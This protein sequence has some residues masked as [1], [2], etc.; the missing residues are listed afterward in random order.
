MPITVVVVSVAQRTTTWLITS[1]QR[2]ISARRSSAYSPNE[3]LDHKNRAG[4]FLAC[5]PRLLWLYEQEQF[6]FDQIFFCRLYSNAL[7]IKRPLITMPC[8]EMV[9]WRARGSYYYIVQLMNSYRLVRPPPPSSQPVSQLAVH[10]STYPNECKWACRTIKLSL[11]NVQPISERSSRGR[12]RGPRRGLVIVRK[13]P[14][15][16]PRC[17]K[18]KQR[19]R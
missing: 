19:D 3:H 6:I 4:F 5:L 9:Y 14:S 18:S 12:R 13:S 16:Q 7:V 2:P 15:Q 11:I 8:T 10:P 17:A 1:V